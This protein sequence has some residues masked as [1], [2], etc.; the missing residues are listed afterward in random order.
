M[1]HPVREFVLFDM[2]F[3]ICHRSHLKC[4]EYHLFEEKTR[5]DQLKA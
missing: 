5:E 4:I 2:V 3:D 1:R